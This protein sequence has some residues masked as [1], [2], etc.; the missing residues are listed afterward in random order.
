M[1]KPPKES[2]HGCWSTTNCCRPTRVRAPRGIGNTSGGSSRDRS[3]RH[4]EVRT[5]KAGAS[6]VRAEGLDSDFVF[7]G[8]G[9]TP[10]W[11]IPDAAFQR[12]ATAPFGTLRMTSGSASLDVP[13]TMLGNATAR[14]FTWFSWAPRGESRNVGVRI[15]GALA[16][17]AR[18]APGVSAA[19]EPLLAPKAATTRI[20]TDG[21]AF[22]PRALDPADYRDRVGI[23]VVRIR[24]L[25]P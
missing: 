15:D 9:G 24:A 20:E 5:E 23:G 16:W 21:D 17:R 6:L 7:A 19:T 22:D 11:G 10:S 12:A 8:F 18:V 13:S 3:A 2:R 25:R 14:E 4:R 1:L